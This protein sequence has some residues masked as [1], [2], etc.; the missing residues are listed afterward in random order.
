MAPTAALPAILWAQKTQM[1]HRE[2]AVRPGY[3]STEAAAD[4]IRTEGIRVF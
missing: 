1:I 4:M 2:N 3:G